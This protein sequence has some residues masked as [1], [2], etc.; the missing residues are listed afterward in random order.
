MPPYLKITTE[1]WWN[2]QPQKFLEPRYLRW[3]C[4][5]VQFSCTLLQLYPR[6]RPTQILLH[7]QLHASHNMQTQCPPSNQLRA[8]ILLLLVIAFIINDKLLFQKEWA[9]LHS[10]QQTHALKVLVVKRNVKEFIHLDSV[11]HIQ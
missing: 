11:K 6:I 10:N 7:Q 2:Q 8:F 5:A 1:W 3:Y 9:G 4:Q